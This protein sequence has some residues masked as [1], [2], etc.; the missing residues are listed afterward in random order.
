M[1][2]EEPIVITETGMY[3]LALTHIP[4]GMV[5][6]IPS[7]AFEDPAFTNPAGRDVAFQALVDTIAAAGIWDITIALKTC[8]AHANVTPT[9]VP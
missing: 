7:L 9:P 4:T 2:Y 1:P 8:G 3:H 5:T 6:N